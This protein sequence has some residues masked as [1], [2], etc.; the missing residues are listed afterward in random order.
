MSDKRAQNI[1]RKINVSAIETTGVNRFGNA[2]VQTLKLL[3][4]NVELYINRTQNKKSYGLGFKFHSIIEQGHSAFAQTAT[5]A[6]SL[7][8][9][10]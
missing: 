8:Y 3:W 9:L 7:F 4:R 5:E 1:S 2:L 10:P 6:Y